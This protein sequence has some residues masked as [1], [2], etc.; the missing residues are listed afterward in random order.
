[1]DDLLHPTEEG[2][3]A[4]AKCVLEYSH[5]AFQEIME[6]S[7]SLVFHKWGD[8]SA[9]CGGGYHI[10][11]SDCKLETDFIVGVDSEVSQRVGR[12]ACNRIPVN[13][14][15]LVQ[16]CNT[17]ACPT[18]P[19]PPPST[20]EPQESILAWGDN[21]REGED[22]K[23]KVSPAAVATEERP[24][25]PTIS[26]PTA[27]HLKQRTPSLADW[28][29]MLSANPPAFDDAVPSIVEDAD[30]PKDSGES[31]I[32]KAPAQGVSWSHTPSDI[33]S[34]LRTSRLVDL[35]FSQG[36]GERFEDAGAEVPEFVI[37][38]IVA[39]CTCVVVTLCGGATA[40]VCYVRKL[41]Q[42]RQRLL[43]ECMKNGDNDKQTKAV[44]R[45]TVAHAQHNLK[46]RRVTEETAVMAQIMGAHQG[47]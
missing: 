20:S 46:W 34:S 10:R 29:S 17:D 1:M 38:A 9:P 14:R 6:K 16:A 30:A 28:F 37:I 25:P 33:K 26:P 44:E 2:H 41:S 12:E 21:E 45:E 27:S 7:T 36:G 35:T 15:D 22:N 24:T 18:I 13:G 39:I 8:C 31:D 23:G 4:L 47:V 3:K 11:D 42:E 43:E 19:P 5:K 40:Y 32:A